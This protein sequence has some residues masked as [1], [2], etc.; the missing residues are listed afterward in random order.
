MGSKP[1]EPGQPKRSL[2]S[3]E[4]QYQAD[5]SAFVV[6]PN[7]D[8]IVPLSFSREEE[9]FPKPTS[10]DRTKSNRRPLKLAWMRKLIIPAVALLILLFVLRPQ[11]LTYHVAAI[12][13]QFGVS[14]SE[15]ESILQ[16]AAERWNSALQKMAIRID[17]NTAGNVISFVFDYRQQ[18]RVALA[19]I[20]AQYFDLGSTELAIEQ[21]RSSLDFEEARLKQESVSLNN[22]VKYWNARGGATGATYD[23]LVARRKAY[24]SDA[25]VLAQEMTAHNKRVAAYNARIAEYNDTLGVVEQQFKLAGGSATETAIG[26]YDPNDLSIT[27]YSYS[28]R[29]HLRLIL[30]HEL[31]HALGCDHAS[32]QGSI[33]YPELTDAQNLTNPVPTTQDLALVGGD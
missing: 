26:I 32:T 6:A 22:D 28:D 27:V 17:T 2:H 31:G 7:G 12:D 29:Q 21:E 14:E 15:V 23:S 30:M 18:Y 9:E 3:S 24:N 16:D 5:P 1:T 33:M 20:E 4:E 11:P 8:V 25:Q 19:F 10:L 13:P